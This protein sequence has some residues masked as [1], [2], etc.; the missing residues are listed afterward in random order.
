MFDVGST[1]YLWLKALH[2]ISI[3]TWMAGIFYLPRLFVY[4]AD[5][6]VGSDQDLTFRT[7]E[8][9]LMNIIMTPS[10]I[11]VLAT[12]MALLPP[13]LSSGWMHL[14]LLMVAVI[15]GSHFFFW[16]LRLDFS[17]GRNVRSGRFYRIVNEVPTVAFLVVVIMVIVRP[18]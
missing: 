12:G 14:K 17:Q 5:A 15:I 8:Q 3:T 4:H 9:K 13:W 7:M 18:F 6:V 10:L 16:R 2:V 1:A 11:V